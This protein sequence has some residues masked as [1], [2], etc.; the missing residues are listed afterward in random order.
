IWV[1]D[2]RF[3][4]IPLFKCD[5]FNHRV[6]GVKRDTTLGYTLVDMNNLGHKTPPK[7]YKDT[8]DEVDEEFST[9]IHQHNDNILPR[10]DQRDLDS[11]NDSK[12]VSSKGPSITS[13]P[14]EGSSVAKLSKEPIPKELLAWYGYDIVEDYLPVAE[15]PI[16]KVIFKSP[17]LIKRCVLGLANIEKWDNIVKKYGMRTPGRCTDKSKGKRKV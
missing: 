1:L 4:Q 6:G 8:Y 3:R 17:N 12:G 11:S 16:P 14:K 5:R 15:K 10:V 13:I 7:N 2:Y 9:I